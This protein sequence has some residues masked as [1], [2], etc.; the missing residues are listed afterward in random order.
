[1][2]DSI[3][4]RFADHVV[5]GD[6][7]MGS[8]LVSR[9]PAGAALETA[10][11]T[12]PELVLDIHLGLSQGGRGAHRDRDLRR[13]AA[14]VGAR[15]G[16]GSASR[17][18]TPTAV[19]LA[20]EAREIAGVDC[21]V[22][23]A[24]GPLAGVIDLDEPDGPSAIAAAHAEQAQIL[25]GRGADLLMLETFFRFDELALAVKAVREVCDLPLVGLLDL[26]HR[27]ASPPVRRAGAGG[28]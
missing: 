15:P 5:V 9:L 21:L 8:E 11:L 22:A 24:I 6:G 28:G 27:A 20:R 4:R 7:S 19:K 26:R 1:M 14:A 2:S 16:R 18:S 17:P 3:R 23:G 13:L 10:P 25:A 12:H